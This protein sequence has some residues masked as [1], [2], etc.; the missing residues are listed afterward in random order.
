MKPSSKIRVIWQEMKELK[1][2]TEEGLINNP[3]LLELQDKFTQI[4]INF[5][6]ESTL[7]KATIYYLD[8]QDKIKN[9]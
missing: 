9:L 4:E 5:G 7:M 3:R 2:L 1:R 8:N 6:H